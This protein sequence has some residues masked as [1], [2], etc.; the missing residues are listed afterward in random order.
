MVE[1]PLKSEKEVMIKELHEKF[2]RTKSAVVA[3]LAV[4]RFSPSSPRMRF[5]N[6]GSPGFSKLLISQL[7]V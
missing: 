5:S 2:A 6:V 1:A 7:W 4:I 3:E